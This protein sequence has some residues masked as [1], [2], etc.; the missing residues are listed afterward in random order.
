M[1][2]WESPHSYKSQVWKKAGDIAGE[3][4]T[5]DLYELKEAETSHFN[6]ICIY[7]C[8]EF[9]ISTF[10]VVCVLLS[11]Q[12]SWIIQLNNSKKNNFLKKTEMSQFFHDWR[13]SATSCS[14]QKWLRHNASGK[15]WPLTLHRQ[16]VLF[17]DLLT[18]LR[19]F[20]YFS[21]LA[22]RTGPGGEGSAAP[23]RHSWAHLYVQLLLLD[24]NSWRK[25]P[26][27]ELPRERG[28]GQ[29]CSQLNAAMLGVFPE[30]R[31]GSLSVPKKNY[32]VTR[33]NTFQDANQ[34]QLLKNVCWQWRGN[35]ERGD[36]E[37]WPACSEPDR[38][39]ITGLWCSSQNGHNEKY[40][41]A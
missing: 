29:P 1:S 5:S 41:W 2:Q 24:P 14:S 11:L 19:P 13:T 25:A 7:I 23:C 40:V 37:W 18:R 30:K 4:K 17:I 28:A 26:F 6:D 33:W 9:L 27:P 32:K 34:R 20:W 21:P 36:W 10:A 12:F 31:E 8:R 16:N 15:L 35:L 39:F 38:C 3:M 22:L